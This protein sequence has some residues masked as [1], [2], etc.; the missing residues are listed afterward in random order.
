[1]S[2]DLCVTLRTLRCISDGNS[3]FLDVDFGASENNERS[4]K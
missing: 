4:N 3:I 1:M 2:N